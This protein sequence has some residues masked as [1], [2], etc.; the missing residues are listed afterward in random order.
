MFD[1][2]CIM[3]AGLLAIS[4]IK[5]YQFLAGA[6][7]FEFSAHSILYR[8]GIMETGLFNPDLIYLS[9][10]AL[11]IFVMAYLYFKKSHFVITGLIF[12]NLCINLLSFQEFQEYKF[13]SIYYVYPFLV[14]TI[15]I[16]ELIYL[17]LLNQ[18][19]SNF[20]RKH[21]SRDLNY[22]DSVF[23]IRPRNS[24]GGVV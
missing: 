12:I 7:F 16:F 20:R 5:E 4:S 9:Y 19:V 24:C 8:G 6:V 18:Y 21:G 14:G 23:R 3:I 10:A 11:Q 22:I 1:S 13:M 17:G 2:I 15:M